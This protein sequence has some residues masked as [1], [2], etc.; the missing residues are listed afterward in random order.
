MTH[1]NLTRRKRNRKQWSFVKTKTFPSGAWNVQHFLLPAPALKHLHARTGWYVHRTSK[2]QRR[3][4]SVSRVKWGFVDITYGPKK[5]GARP[6]FDCHLLRLHTPVES[7]AALHPV[8]WYTGPKN[9]I[10]EFRWNNRL[11]TWWYIYICRHIF[12]YSIIVLQTQT[13]SG[14]TVKMPPTSVT[15][16]SPVIRC[17]TVCPSTVVICWM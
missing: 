4:I 15:W 5:V 12:I 14:Y 7:A 10:N 13:G 1:G 17:W 11:K 2:K 9:K 3:E 6:V 8:R 16:L